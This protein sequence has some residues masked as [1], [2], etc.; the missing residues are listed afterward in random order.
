LKSGFDPEKICF[1]QGDLAFFQC[2]NAITAGNGTPC[3]DTIY[4]NEEPIQKMFASLA[5]ADFAIQNEHIPRCPNCGSPLVPNIRQDKTF[6]EKPWTGQYQK[7]FDFIHAFERKNILLLELG[8]GVNTPG[9]IRYPFEFMT[10]E[11]NNT[12]LVRIN[13]NTH[14]LTLLANSE[15]AAII[16]ADIGMLLGEI[17]K[18]Y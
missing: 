4:P 8:V 6:V 9:I 16:P 12:F 3:N 18:D 15:K 17:A 5:P 2:S 1:P 10:L 7:L 14:N 13:L 11:R